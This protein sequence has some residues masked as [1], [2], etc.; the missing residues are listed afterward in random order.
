MLKSAGSR[1]QRSLQNVRMSSLIS[2][3]FT[4]LRWT[5]RFVEVPGSRVIVLLI[6]FWLASDCRQAKSCTSSRSGLRPHRTGWM[7]CSKIMGS[8]ARKELPTM[9]LRIDGWKSPLMDWC[10]CCV[11]PMISYKFA[12]QKHWFKQNGEKIGW[13]AGSLVSEV[14][15]P[16]QARCDDSVQGLAGR[17]VQ[18]G[19]ECS[20]A[21]VRILCQS[22][23]CVQGRVFSRCGCVFWGHA[24]QTAALGSAVRSYEAREGRVDWE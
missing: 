19:S 6:V 15:L 18:R 20:V 21:P 24:G 4:S 23:G 14:S 9:S 7:I 2:L 8:S 10:L 22:C 5:Q 11:H 13:C 1:L 17:S 12:K 3:S 16:Q